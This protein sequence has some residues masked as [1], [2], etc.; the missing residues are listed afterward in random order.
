MKKALKR[1]RR[2]KN[3][4]KCGVKKEQGTKKCTEVT[5]EEAE[6]GRMVTARIYIDVEDTKHRLYG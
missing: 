6:N 1:Q 4:G 2:K 3:G 5:R